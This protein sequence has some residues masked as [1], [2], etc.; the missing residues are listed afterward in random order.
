MTKTIPLT[1]GLVAIVDDKDYELLGQYKWYAHKNT[2]VYYAQRRAG[3]RIV[4]MHR[5]ILGLQY[6]DKQIVDHAN[7]NGL[8]NRH[9]NLRFATPSQSVI[10]RRL[11]TR[12]KT[13][14][15][16]VSYFQ[17]RYRAFIYLR[18]EQYY[19]GSF[20]TDKEAALAYNAAA[21]KYHGEFA[22]LNVLE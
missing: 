5:E 13:G 18:R 9:Q 21:P 14:Y 16:G 20:T 7:G 22:R 3:K 10:N 4:S 2:D 11:S 6:G 1:Q 17:G 12:N 15:R 19:L 8:D